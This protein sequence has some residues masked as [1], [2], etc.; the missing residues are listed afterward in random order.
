M[1]LIYGEKYIAEAYKK[2]A[3]LLKDEGGSPNSSHLAGVSPIIKIRKRA[4][5]EGE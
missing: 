4:Q 2:D 1:T 3:E 5:L